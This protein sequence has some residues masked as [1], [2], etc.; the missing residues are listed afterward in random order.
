MKKLITIILCLLTLTT[1]SQVRMNEA[2]KLIFNMVNSYRVSQGLE[3]VT[4]SDK[5][6]ES[7]YHH[8]SYMSNDGVE[9]EHTEMVDIVG[10][11]E[12]N[13]VQQRIKKYCGIYS[14]GTECMAGLQFWSLDDKPFDLESS[15]WEVVSSWILSPGHRKAMLFDLEGN[16][17][18]QFGAVSVILNEYENSVPVLVLTNSVD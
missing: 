1:Y 11:E 16:G 6:Y 5:V 7:A 10:H 12:I 17:N 8:S 4:W 9:F 13:D 18:L 14:W 15:C 3:E 2:E